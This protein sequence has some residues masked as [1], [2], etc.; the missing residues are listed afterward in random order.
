MIPPEPTLILSVI[1]ATW[2]IMTSGAVLAIV[3]IL[4]CSAN[5]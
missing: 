1:D 2:A 4:W 3:G 5:Q